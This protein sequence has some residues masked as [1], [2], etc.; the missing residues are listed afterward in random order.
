VAQLPCDDESKALAAGLIDDGQ[1]PELA[2]I[3]IAKVRTSELA[4]VFSPHVTSGSLNR[5]PRRTK[6]EAR[7]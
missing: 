6:T 7:P 5:T 2:P 1:D 3:K 4:K